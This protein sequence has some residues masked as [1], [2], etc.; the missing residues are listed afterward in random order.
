M[1]RKGCESLQQMIAPKE[2]EDAARRFGPG[3]I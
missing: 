3:G 2:K 1:L